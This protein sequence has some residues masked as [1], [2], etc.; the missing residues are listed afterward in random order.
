M[1]TLRATKI[2]VFLM[3]IALLFAGGARADFN[4]ALDQ[5]INEV[6]QE[7]AKK[8]NETEFEDVK[9]IA[10]LP[11]WGQG[12]A[13]TKGYIVTAIQSQ[14]VGGPYRVMERDTRAWE[15]LLSEIKWETLREDIMNRETVQ[16]FGNIEGCDAILYGTV[17]ECASDPVT[18]TAVTRLTLRLGVVET[19]EVKW[20]SGE[21]KKVKIVQEA[22]DA[23]GTLDS[24]LVKAINLAAEKAAESLKG[25]SLSTKGFAFF[26]LS[27]KDAD[28]YVS[29][30]LQSQLA[31]AGCS[32]VPVSK[33]QWQEYLVA[34][35]STAERVETMR[36]FAKEKGSSAV[37]YGTVNECR[38]L[39]RKYKAVVRMTLNMVNAETGESIW[40]PGEI[41]GQA[42]LDWQDI[43]RLAVSDP[44]VWVLAAVIILLIV[45]RTFKR[46]FREATRPR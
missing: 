36:D 16:R 21:I 22:L 44:V 1:V 43:I 7:V 17:R 42:R 24:A 6:A 26:P 28:N 8:L 37:L 9:N 30:V 23:S 31:K 4:R 13:S 25:K 46:L 32:L 33:M 27:G 34:N 29:D 38:V 40:S 2:T 41:V 35:S 20:S 11:L 45:W 14:I 15:Q 12:D 10:I 5:T 39:E 18:T 19:G 3:A